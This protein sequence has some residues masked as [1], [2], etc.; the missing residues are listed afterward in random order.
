MTLV[1]VLPQIEFLMIQKIIMQIQTLFSVAIKNA[2]EVIPLCSCQLY[3][4]WNDF[5]IEVISLGTSTCI[6]VTFHQFTTQVTENIQRSASYKFK[7]DSQLFS[8]KWC[9]SNYSN[10]LISCCSQMK[11]EIHHLFQGASSHFLHLILL[12]LLQ[13]QGQRWHMSH[14][15]MFQITI[16]W[17]RMER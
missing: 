4:N 13:A 2:E 15:R 16:I 17:C 10:V 7:W 8:I 14:L 6:A 11:L 1:L 5:F 9:H 3:S 12:P